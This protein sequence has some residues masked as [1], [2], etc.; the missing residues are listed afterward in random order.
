MLI[1]AVDLSEMRGTNAIVSVHV[2]SAI[3][4]ESDPCTYF[5]GV[6]RGAGKIVAFDIIIIIE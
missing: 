6:F 5:Q 4:V 3:R 2:C 1:E